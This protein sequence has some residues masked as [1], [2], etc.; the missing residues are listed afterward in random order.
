MRPL[1]IGGILIAKTKK[2]QYFILKIH[3]KRLRQAKW[4]LQIDLQQARMR[5][6][7]VTLT[8]SQMLRWLDE[9][10]GVQDKTAEIAAVRK[11]IRAVAAQETSRTR[12]AQLK[13]LYAQLDELQYQKDYVCLIID[14]ER[15]Y[16]TAVNGFYIN[17]TRYVRLLG[18][19]GGIKMNTI[20]F[21]N[22]EH[23]DELRRRI[24]NGRN[25]EMKLVP[26]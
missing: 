5:D 13:K 4:N 16:R 18:T 14:D 2:S 15:D 11:E 9:L 12:K 10:N 26:A 6:E 3:S 7:L 21:V 20:V 19:N 1:V 25:P 8:G 17:D 22:A 23:A 24:D